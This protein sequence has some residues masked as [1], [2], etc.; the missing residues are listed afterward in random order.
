MEKLTINDIAKLAGVSTATV[1]NF[2]NHNYGKMSAKTRA[3]VA[4]IITEH[5]YHPNSVARD[6]AKNDNKTIGFQLLTSPI[7]SP[8]PSFLESR[9]FLIKRVTG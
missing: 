3:H 7:P 1:S 2:L 8:P 6:L 4:K 5:N 9:R